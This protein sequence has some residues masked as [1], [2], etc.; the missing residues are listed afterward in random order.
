MGY[1]FLM[2]IHQNYVFLVDFFN[3]I[4]NAVQIKI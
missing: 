1:G 3:V 2:L 4:V